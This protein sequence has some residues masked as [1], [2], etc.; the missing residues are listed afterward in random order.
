MVIVVS[1]LGA[2]ALRL[3]PQRAVLAAL[4][5]PLLLIP[6]EVASLLL[7]LRGSNRA[8]LPFGIGGCLL[9]VG[10]VALD[11]IATIVY[12]PD[13]AREANP[14]ARLLLDSGYSVRFVYGYG[15]CGQ[16]LL[17]LVLCTLWLALLRHK[18]SI[19]D[20]PFDPQLSFGA[21]YRAVV[22]GK[23]VTVRQFYFPLRRS[24]LKSPYRVLW[25]LVVGACGCSV[26]YRWY[27]GFEWIGI[28]PIG[29]EYRW[30]VVG[31]GAMCAIGSYVQW[32]KLHYRRIQRSTP[33]NTAD[34]VPRDVEQHPRE[35]K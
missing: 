7:L 24:E 21:Y 30:E 8:S 2:G 6:I 34:V 13:L 25:L 1:A 19:V 14:L 20:F 29:S 32:L 18:D 31:I 3:D 4:A 10:G 23:A 12:T 11:V 28:A 15:L 33:P 17:S 9:I 16:S 22:A 26:P 35:A 5:I 27:L